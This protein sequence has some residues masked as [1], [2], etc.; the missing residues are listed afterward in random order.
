MSGLP[1]VVLSLF[2]K[3][4][5]ARESGPPVPEY[6]EE[7]QRDTKRYVNYF[8]LYVV[9]SISW[10]FLK[11]VDIPS[12]SNGRGSKSEL[13]LQDEEDGDV[14]WLAEAHLR[15][16]TMSLVQEGDIDDVPSDLCRAQRPFIST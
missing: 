7:A 5:L 1:R 15:F 2:R 16:R 13:I 3:A 10:C 8:K 14:V 11:E 6:D 9:H 12:S 4:H